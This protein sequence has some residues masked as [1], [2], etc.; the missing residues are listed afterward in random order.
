MAQGK[1]QSSVRLHHTDLQPLEIDYTN[2]YHHVI[3]SS[4]YR[5]P[6]SVLS[7]K[8][9]SAIS[10]A[11]PSLLAVHQNYREHDL[12]TALQATLPPA[13]YRIRPASNL[14][15][16][17][18]VLSPGGL[19]IRIERIAFSSPGAPRTTIY[20]T[21]R[22]SIA[23]ESR[24][25]LLSGI[26]RSELARLGSVVTRRYSSPHPNGPPAIIGK[27]PFDNTQNRRRKWGRVYIGNAATADIIVKAVPLR[28]AGEVTVSK[29]DGEVKKEKMATER[30]KDTD[31]LM[32][33]TSRRDIIVRARIVP[34]TKHRRP[35]LI[36]R[37][38]NLDEMQASLPKTSTDK[39]AIRAATSEDEIKC[40]PQA[41]N[42]QPSLGRS[43]SLAMTQYYKPFEVRTAENLYEQA[44][45][46]SAFESKSGRIMPIRESFI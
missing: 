40:P 42:A 19:A 26:N 33:I 15:R 28:R 14:P 45:P 9:M 17:H 27:F 23:E 10:I 44:L 29:S 34:G 38:F 2:T 11:S 35:F 36:Q 5:R 4:T 1:V 6:G 32:P 16:R 21:K 31:N 46:A 7:M 37:R 30:S 18:S 25:I 12:K 13:G 3:N 41:I 43:R 20:G 8:P 22:R 39:G 24:E